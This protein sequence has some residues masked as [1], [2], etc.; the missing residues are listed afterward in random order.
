MKFNVG[1]RV[2]FRNEMNRSHAEIGT[3]KLVV[4]TA[5]SDYPYRVSLDSWFDEDYLFLCKENELELVE[6][7]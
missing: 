2:V 6:C 4:S 1:D 5:V 3:V 7:K